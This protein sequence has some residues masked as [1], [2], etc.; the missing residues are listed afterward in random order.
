M[1]LHVGCAMWIHKA[2]QGR[3]FAP[4][5]P[6]HDRLRAHAL[7]IQLPRSFSPSDV[8]ALASF[9]RRLPRSHRYAVAVSHPAFFAEPHTT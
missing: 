5:A 6:A 7:W 2:W 3:F 9:L 8:P 4:P 1:R